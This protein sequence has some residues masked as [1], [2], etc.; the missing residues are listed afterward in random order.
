M[1]ATGLTDVSDLL[2]DLYDIQRQAKLHNFGSL[3]KDSEGAETT[4]NDCLVHLINELEIYEMLEKM[5]S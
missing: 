4:I 5:V 1:K 3:P 2:L